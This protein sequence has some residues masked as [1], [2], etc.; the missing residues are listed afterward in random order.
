MEKRKHYSATDKVKILREY[1]E[2]KMSISALSEKYSV[3]PTQIHSWKKS[4]F[5]GA[6]DTFSGKHKKKN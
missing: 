3:H 4:L 1:L 2:S 5:E 6:L